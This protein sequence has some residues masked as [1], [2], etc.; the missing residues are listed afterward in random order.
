MILN[1]DSELSL[2]TD[3]FSRLIKI[4]P[5]FHPITRKNIDW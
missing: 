3:Q 4:P 5:V 2:L 1:T